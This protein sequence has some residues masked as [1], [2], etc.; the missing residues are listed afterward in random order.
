MPFSGD[1]GT[2]WRSEP[3]SVA[4][5]KQA[6]PPEKVAKLKKGPPPTPGRLP[7]QGVPPDQGVPPEKGVP[8]EVGLPPGEGR[9]P[10]VE[11]QRPKGA[12]G[13]VDRGAPGQMDPWADNP[14]APSGEG[15]PEGWEPP[16]LPADID[17]GDGF[18]MNH[19]NFQHRDEVMK[20]LDEAQGAKTGA[21]GHEED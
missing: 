14:W 17:E 11:G 16:P 13:Q 9:L 20:E 21:G 5:R 7:G 18:Y 10:G 3:R 1:K 6:I 8:P 19:P 4:T 2:P 12:P 15:G